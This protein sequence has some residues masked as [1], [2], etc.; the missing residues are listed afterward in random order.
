MYE[1]PL[2]TLTDKV[3][4]YLRLLVENN[5]YATLAP[6][7]EHLISNQGVI[8]SNPISSLFQFSQA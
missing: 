1:I 7:V 5:F 8:G 4:P 6:T 3:A 2:R